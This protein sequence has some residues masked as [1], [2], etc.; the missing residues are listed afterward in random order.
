MVNYNKQKLKDA[1]WSLNGSHESISVVFWE[2]SL[3]I[4]HL[5][6]LRWVRSPKANFA[7]SEGPF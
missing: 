2:Q 1:V 5:V 7:T 4:E 6:K 3:S